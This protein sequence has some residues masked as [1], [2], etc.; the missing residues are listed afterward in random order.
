MLLIVKMEKSKVIFNFSLLLIIGTTSALGY[1]FLLGSVFQLDYP[2]DS[3]LFWSEADYS[4]FFDVY[5]RSKISNPYTHPQAIYFPLNYVFAKFFT[6]FKKSLAL[7]LFQ[8]SFLVPF[9]YMIKDIVKNQPTKYCRWVCLYGLVLGSYP[10]LFSFFRAN[11]EFIVFFFTF[12]FLISY[13][14]KRYILSAVFLSF[15]IGM[16]LYPAIFGVLFLVDKK[17]KEIFYTIGITIIS[18]IIALYWLGGSVIGTLS[19][20]ISNLQNFNMKYI[21]TKGGVAF[22]HS[23]FNFIN[24]FSSRETTQMLMKPYMLMALAFF[25]FIIY[26]LRE[27]N[28]LWQKVLV[29]SASMCLLPYLSNDYKLIYFY[30]P[31]YFLAEESKISVND[32]ITIFIMSLLFIPKRFMFFTGE[33]S[34]FY[35][36]SYSALITPVILSTLILV[37]INK[38]TLGHKFEPNKC[39]NIS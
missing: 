30:L 1:H 18:N 39:E 14:K 16:K 13:K 11:F 8:L 37:V 17:Y 27:N 36:V 33:Y 6:L 25:G 9:Y 32:V 24:I 21:I 10:F 31:L 26:K 28:E 7:R 22:S 23:A 5:E 35:G 20:F 3:F 38:K 34:G 2:Y 15:A 19:M 4:D 12:L 29:L